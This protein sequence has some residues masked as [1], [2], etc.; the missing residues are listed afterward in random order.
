MAADYHHDMSSLPCEFGGDYS[1]HVT[2]RAGNKRNFVVH[3]H[4]L[5][6]IKP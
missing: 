2:I 4:F 1:A 6:S 3:H 5:L